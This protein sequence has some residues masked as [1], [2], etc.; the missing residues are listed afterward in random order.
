MPSTTQ[1]LQRGKRPAAPPTLN[2]LNI[3]TNEMP[4]KKSS[5]ILGVILLSSEK[6]DVVKRYNEAK[7][8]M[9]D[10]EAIVKELEPTIK[11]A[12][13]SGIFKHNCA[14]TT[15]EPISSVKV[16]DVLEDPENPD[17]EIKGELCRVTFQNRYN[18]CDSAVVEA[19]FA[20]FKDRNIN[21]YVAEVV[22]AGFDHKIWLN[23]DGTM[24]EAA[25]N[26]V[27]AAIAKVASELG[28]VDEKGAP[29]TPLRTVKK[30]RPLEDFHQR[31]F[32]D[33]SVKENVVLYQVLPNTVAATPLRS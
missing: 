20:D 18:N 2:R 25:Y 7:K 16:Q 29:A 26:K 13:M 14:D 31:R 19:A 28:F 33:F 5:G 24:N 12:G 32:L 27:T 15:V 1:A 9:Q 10:N 6:G 8:L 21:D 11:S 4:E 22:E 17:V 3:E 23:K 30:V